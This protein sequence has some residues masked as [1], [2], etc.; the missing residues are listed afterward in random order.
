M[1]RKKKPLLPLRLPK[2][3]LP[4]LKPLRPPLL[5]PLR[6]PLLKP[7]RLPKLPR[8]LPSPPSN[9]L[10]VDEKAGLRAGAAKRHPSERH[11]SLPLRSLA[12]QYSICLPAASRPP[13]PKDSAT[14]TAT[15]PNTRAKAMLTM[16]SEMPMADSPIARTRP[17]I[18]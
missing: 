1:A 7:L 11:H 10:L 9:S 14:A 13:R 8:L 5:K 6:L 4:L 16:S 12:S 2:L 17:S 15:A 18:A 3:L